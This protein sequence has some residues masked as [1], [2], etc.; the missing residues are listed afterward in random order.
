VRSH[1]PNWLDRVLLYDVNF[2]CH[3]E[4]HAHPQVPSCHLPSVQLATGA[5]AMPKSMFATLH[6]IYEVRKALRA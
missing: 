2:N 6:D 4:H 1:Q 3:A 5:P